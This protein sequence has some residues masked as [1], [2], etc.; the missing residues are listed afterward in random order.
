M[1]KTADLL[2]SHPDAQVCLLQLRSFGAPSFAGRV[3][4]V[5]CFEDN[6][7]VRQRLGSSGEGRVLVVARSPGRS[8]S[9]TVASQTS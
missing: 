3:A 8:G 9:P 5:R 1:T 2:D 7:L 6:G 4:T